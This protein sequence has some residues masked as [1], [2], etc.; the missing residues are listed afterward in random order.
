MFNISSYLYLS[1]DSNESDSVQNSRTPI[2]S[3]FTKTL[4]HSLH[5]RMN[6]VRNAWC[7]KG[8]IFKAI[9][10]PVVEYEKCIDSVSTTKK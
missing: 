5:N 4:F 3:P 9:L 8:P 10:H 7:K 2:L 1:S 6:L